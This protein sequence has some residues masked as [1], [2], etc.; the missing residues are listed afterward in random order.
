MR[1]PEGDGKLVGY[2]AVH[3]HDEAANLDWREVLHLVDADEHASLDLGRGDPN[4]P[5]RLGDTRST[6]SAQ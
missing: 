4:V 5:N 6:G 1:H 3:A 2:R